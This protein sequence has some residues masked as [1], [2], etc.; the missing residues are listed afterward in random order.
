MKKLILICLI[1]AFLGC[2]DVDKPE[3]P[4]NLIPENT[5]AEVLAEAYLSNAARSI[6]NRVIR[7]EGVKLDSMIYQKYNIDSLQFVKSHAYYTS[8]LGAYNDLFLQVEAHIV[9]LTVIN[10]SLNAIEK[11][12]KDSLAELMK[13]SVKRKRKDTVAAKDTLAVKPSLVDPATI[14]MPQDTIE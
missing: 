11:K 10:D 9:K 13:D 14:R 6:N 12:R 8:D 2:Q 5:M 7:K 3:K 4:K 1:G